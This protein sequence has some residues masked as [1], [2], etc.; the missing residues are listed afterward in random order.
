MVPFL[1]NGSS[2]TVSFLNPLASLVHERV[3][4]HTQH[5]HATMHMNIHAALC[6]LLCADMARS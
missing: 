6:A 4:E 2:Y 1:D 5:W 3:L